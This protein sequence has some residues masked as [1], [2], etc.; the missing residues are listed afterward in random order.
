M[1]NPYFVRE[2]EESDGGRTCFTCRFCRRYY[3]DGFEYGR[4]ALGWPLMEKAER[5]LPSQ[6]C[7]AHEYEGERT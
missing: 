7:E 2:S 5:L 3:M 6:I 1:T 4:C